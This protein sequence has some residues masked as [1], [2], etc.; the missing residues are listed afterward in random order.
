VFLVNFAPPPMPAVPFNFIT[1]AN[2]GTSIVRGQNLNVQWNVTR[3]DHLGVDLQHVSAI[4][5]SFN[6]TQRYQNI[7][8]KFGTSFATLYPDY[9]PTGDQSGPSF[10]Y[11]GTQ[12]GGSPKF[13]VLGTYDHVF[14]FGDTE[15]TPQVVYRYVGQARNGNQQA[16]NMPP[17]DAFWE[18][19]SYSTWDLTLTFGSADGKYTVAAFARNLADEL[20][21][22]GRGYV[23]GGQAALLPASSRYAFTT[24]TY[25][26]PRTYGITVRASF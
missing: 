10:N 8:A 15:F 24:A 26:P 20:Y 23:N 5:T 1:V 7:A 25:G 3:N 18:L 12:V 11:N 19:P 17:D 22:T 4:F 14:H 9:S 6:L 2:A 13:T 21:T 16:P